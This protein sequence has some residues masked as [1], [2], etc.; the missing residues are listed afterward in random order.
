MLYGRLDTLCR[1]WVLMNNN[2]GRLNE[3]GG[4]E[5]MQTH[6][7]RTSGN[8]RM[9]TAAHEARQTPMMSTEEEA[10]TRHLTKRRVT[11]RAK[12]NI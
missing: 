1:R 11:L 4:A 12:L 9:S 5:M 6:Q 8:Q 10:L 7:P 2:L 3:D